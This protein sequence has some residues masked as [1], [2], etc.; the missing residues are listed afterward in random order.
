MPLNLRKGWVKGTGLEHP[1]HFHS[2]YTKV[3]EDN[4]VVVWKN[5]IMDK[6]GERNK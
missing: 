5:V 2:S 1:S 3:A 4:D 6:G